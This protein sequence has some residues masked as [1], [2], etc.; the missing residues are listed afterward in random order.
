MRKLLL[1]L[2]L[3]I[4][5]IPVAA[6]DDEAVNFDCTTRGMNQEVDAWYNRYIASR[7]EFDTQQA[8]GATE[9]LADN[10]ASLMVFCDAEST[11]DG[12]E[13]VEQ[14]GIGTFDSPYLGLAP[15]VV[16]DTTIDFEG[17]ILPAN[18]VLDEAGI[19]GVNAIP[20][21]QVYFLVYLRINC[22]RNTTTGCNMN[23]DSFRVIGDEGVSY[24]PTLSEFDDYLPARITLQSGGQRSGAIPFL[25]S[26][27]D[28]NLKLV[29][30]PDAD[31]LDAFANAYYFYA[32]GG[33]DSVEVRTTIDQLRIREAPVDGAPFAVLRN[34]ETAQADGRNSDGSWI[35]IIA[36]RGTGWVASEFLETDGDFLS[37]SI[38]SD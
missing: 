33:G 14:T 27:S 1:L 21:D 20:D 2:A 13:E 18:S 31:A 29:Y 32:E 28:S 11:G 9:T 26:A 35:H 16:G 38:L 34:G 12:G 19:S 4:L 30:Y 17:S 37:L 8:L 3:L 6:Q 22:G 5:V 10:I 25:I 24:I 7:G 23:Q 36:P 15:G